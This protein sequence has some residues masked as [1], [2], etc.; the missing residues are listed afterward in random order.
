M[1]FAAS[2][3]LPVQL[4]RTSWDLLP[5][6]T[7][8]LVWTNSRSR[9]ILAW[10]IFRLS[11]HSPWEPGTT[12]LGSIVTGRT[13]SCSHQHVLCL[14]TRGHVLSLQRCLLLCTPSI[15]HSSSKWIDTSDLLDCPCLFG[16]DPLKSHVLHTFV[17]SV[18]V[19]LRVRGLSKAVHASCRFSLR[20]RRPCLV[21]LVE[22]VLVVP[23]FPSFRPLRETQQVPAK[24]STL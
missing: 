10:D 11:F 6:N 22:P 12:C 8:W 7:A 3:A 13:F 19:V 20:L 24:A 16:Y 23:M 18:Q 4:L 17:P 1:P 14:N 2:L 9:H 15:L 21:S 5:S